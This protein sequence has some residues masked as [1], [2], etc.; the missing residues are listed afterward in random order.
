MNAR[1]FAALLLTFLC[2]TVRAGDDA[3]E[4]KRLNREG[5]KALEKN[6]F[7]RAEALLLQAV[8]KAEA[9]GPEDKRYAESYRPLAHAATQL[10]D[11]QT[12]DLAYTRLAYADGKRL[13]TNDLRVAQDLLDYVEI[14]GYTRQFV[15]GTDALGRATEI[16]EQKLG[17]FSRGMGL[18]YATRAGLELQAHAL[19]QADTNF[20][21][22]LELL[23]GTQTVM[24]FSGDDLQMKQAYFSP[25]PIFVAN[26]LNKLAICQRQ[27][28]KYP[29]A[30]AS[31]RRSLDLLER[32]Y[33]GNSLY[34]FNGLFNLAGVYAD[35]GKLSEAETAAR[36]AVSLAR[37][38]DRSNPT[39]K[40]AHA[41]LAKILRAEGKGA[42]ANKFAQ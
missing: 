6:D 1:I 8:A 31:L 39:V 37:T 23:E 18:C 17:K 29:E 2:P 42:E 12:A 7:T 41:L 24:H 34:L 3:S 35:E 15:L 38:V 22:A 14:A 9:F 19:R 16:V 21:K 27:E 13:G 26:V 30:A 32:E 25:P 40:S 20:Q 36:R 28:K 5:T 33:G 11:Y 4:W 10:Q